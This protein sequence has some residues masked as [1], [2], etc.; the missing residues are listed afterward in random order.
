MSKIFERVLRIVYE[1]LFLSSAELLSKGKSVTIH[2]RN[3]HILAIEM[4]IIIPR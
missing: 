1:D 3:F 2:L 4:Y